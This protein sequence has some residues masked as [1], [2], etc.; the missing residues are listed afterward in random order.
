M[1]VRYLAKYSIKLNMTVVIFVILESFSFIF[2]K[3]L[4]SL[5][6]NIKKVLADV[7]LSLSNKYK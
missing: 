4:F 6:H 3:F 7:E 2:H 5:Y 1:I